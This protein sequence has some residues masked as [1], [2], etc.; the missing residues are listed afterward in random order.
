MVTLEECAEFAGLE[1]SE[2][3]TGA[4]LSAKH[5]SLLASYLFNLKRGHVAVRKMIVSD[6]RAAKARIA[7]RATSMNVRPYTRCGADPYYRVI[8]PS[9][10][11]N[12]YG[13]T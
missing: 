5:R 3:F 6:I 10:P 8:H 12:E 7:R 2:L 9:F 1:S 11:A 13:D 4:V